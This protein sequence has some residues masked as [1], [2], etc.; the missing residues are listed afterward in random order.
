M[1]VADFTLGDFFAVWGI[2]FSSQCIMQYCNDD[3]RRVRLFVDGKPNF[4]FEKLIL[5]DKQDI[6]IEYS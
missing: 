4:N 3:T 2:A 6:L 1:V 5:G